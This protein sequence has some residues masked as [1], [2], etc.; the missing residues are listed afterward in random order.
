MGGAV[1]GT[2]ANTAKRGRID[3]RVMPNEGCLFSHGLIALAIS[4]SNAKVVKG[5][6]VLTTG[7]GSGRESGS[8]W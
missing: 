6:T 7:A 2:F 8:Q 5:L 3:H 4:N 1:H